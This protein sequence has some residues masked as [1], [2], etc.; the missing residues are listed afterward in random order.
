MPDELIT[1]GF[2]LVQDHLG[3]AVDCCLRAREAGATKPNVSPHPIETRQ[4]LGVVLHGYAALEGAANRAKFELF[5][6]NDNPSRVAVDPSDPAQI[7]LCA[8]LQRWQDGVALESKISFVL[9]RYGQTLDKNDENLLREIRQYR[10]LVAHGFVVK[11]LFFVT[12]DEEGGRSFEEDTDYDRKFPR[13][14]LPHPHELRFSGAKGILEVV[15]RTV[16]ILDTADGHT[17][18]VQSWVLPGKALFYEIGRRHRQPGEDN[19]KAILQ[20][21]PDFE[22]G[23]RD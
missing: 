9:G 14:N 1:Y 6:N 4:A 17:E 10:H 18:F 15:L 13:L 19:V 22:I 23:Q 7:P 2:A 8:F 11:N 16:D 21:M 5:D 12:H 3:A 20:H